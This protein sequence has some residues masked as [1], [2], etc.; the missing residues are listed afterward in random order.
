MA[1]APARHARGGKLPREQTA[2]ASAG[3]TAE[4][5]AEASEKLLGKKKISSSSQRPE[6]ARTTQAY[7]V[8]LEI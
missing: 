4:R 7:V 3:T 5:E 8:F 2:N 1:S 6:W